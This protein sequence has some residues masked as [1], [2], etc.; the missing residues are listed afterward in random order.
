MSMAT[1]PRVGTKAHFLGGSNNLMSERNRR[2]KA[3]RA[4]QE[5]QRQLKQ[6]KSELG[7]HVLELSQN[8]KVPDTSI[9]A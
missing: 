1:K 4:L 9:D 6:L 5:A 8:V 2:E 7:P 3:E